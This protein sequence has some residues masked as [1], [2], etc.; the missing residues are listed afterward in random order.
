MLLRGV[1]YGCAFFLTG[2]L[3][4]R[5]VLHS[6]RVTGESAGAE[7]GAWRRR[8]ERDSAR[9]A[10][11]A[12]I[13]LV[14]LDVGRLWHQTYAFY[15]GFEPITFTLA[16]TIVDETLWGSGWQVQ[17]LAAAAAALAFAAVARG[18]AGA[19]LAVVPV[20]FV[21]ASRPLTGHAVEEGSWLSLPAILQAVHVAGAA[22]WLGTLAVMFLFGLGRAGALPRSERARTVAAMVNGFSPLALGAA[23]ALFVAGC[24]TSF[25]YLGSP[26]AIY[27]TGY[28][29]VLSAKV[30][31]FA[32][33]GALGYYNWRRVRPRLE[34]AAQGG[35]AD[36]GVEALLWRAAGTEIALA[37]LVLVL[38][39]V[40]VIL[41]MPAA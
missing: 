36:D 18:W 6:A 16:R 22:L 3:G 7:I 20:A 21:V 12:G 27:G 40:L 17:V 15:G 32:G 33:V 35:V 30:A 9:W 25:I 34:A 23:T 41:P 38:T 39:A 29:L 1:G 13:T 10:M 19:W 11:I 14:A 8:I 24:A 4:V 26:A 2:A 28:G 5:A 31:V 37:A